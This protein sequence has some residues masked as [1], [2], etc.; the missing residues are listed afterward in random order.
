MEAHLIDL[1]S[2]LVGTRNPEQRARV[3]LELGQHALREERPVQ[4][5]RHLEEAVLLDDTLSDAQELLDELE[6]PA[7]KTGSLWGRLFRR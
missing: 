2:R 5:R 4:A 6:P 7:E 3:H 1:Q